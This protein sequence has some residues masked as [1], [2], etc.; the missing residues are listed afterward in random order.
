M[1]GQH[2]SSG[3]QV[4]RVRKKDRMASYLVAYIARETRFDKECQ[5]ETFDRR[6]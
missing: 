4:E 6:E 1:N 3:V 5:H 2:D